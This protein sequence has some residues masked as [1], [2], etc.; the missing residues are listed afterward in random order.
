MPKIQRK[1]IG[2]PEDAYIIGNVGRLSKQKAPDVFVEAAALIK[3]KIPN[4]YFIMVGDG[5]ERSKVEKLIQKYELSKSF[6]ITG[7]VNN[8][9]SYM[10]LFDV[11]TLLSRWEGFGLVLA[12]YMLCG[13]PIVAS[14]VDAIPYVVRDG[15]DGVLVP[16]D[17]PEAVAQKIFSLFKDSSLCKTLINNGKITVQRRFDGKRLAKEHEFLFESLMS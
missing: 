11:G 2:I 14:K 8:A 9:I 16:V 7:W 10:N 12:E 5:N 17:D 6:M 15:E 1:S 3:Q 4:A 13:I